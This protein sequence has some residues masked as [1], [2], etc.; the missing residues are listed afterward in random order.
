MPRATIQQPRPV[1]NVQVVQPLTN[2]C[3]PFQT[4]HRYALFIM[5]IGPFQTFKTFNRCATF[6]TFNGLRI[7]EYFHVSGILETSKRSNKLNCQVDVRTHWKV[8][9]TYGG[10]FAIKNDV[11]RLAKDI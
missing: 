8:S 5:G 1:P 7:A 10:E 2:Y 11:L 3:G 6:K 4:F 9:E